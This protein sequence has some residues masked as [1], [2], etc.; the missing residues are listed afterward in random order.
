MFRPARILLE[1]T[2]F[3]CGAEGA[4][5]TFRFKRTA[6]HA[7]NTRMRMLCKSLF[8]LA[9][10]LVALSRGQSIPETTHVSL[11]KV[12]LRHASNHKTNSPGPTYGSRADPR[13]TSVSIELPENASDK[14]WND[15][16]MRRFEQITG[17]HVTILRPGNDTTLVLKDYLNQFRTDSARADVY[18]IDIVW[19]GLLAEYAEDLRPTFGDLRD[20]VPVLAR[21]DIVD[22]KLVALPYFVEVSLLYYR[23]DLLKKYRFTHPPRTWRELE[24]QARTI[25]AGER[26]DANRNFWGY[27]WQGA[28]SE[29]LTC[30][31]LEWQTSEGGGSL[32]AENGTVDFGRAI[33]AASWGRARQWIGS[34]SPPSTIDQLE[35]DSLTIWKDGGA[36]FMRNWPYA[37]QESMQADSK[38]KGRV[39][40]TMLPKGEGQNGR[41]A[42]TLGGFQLMVSKRSRN[43]QSAIELLKFLTS[44]ESQRL[45]ASRG[46]APVTMDLYTDPTVLHAAPLV[47]ILRNILIDGAI[48]RPSAI[49]GSK[50]DALSS[51]FSTSVHDVLS[52]HTSADSAVQKFS[53]DLEILLRP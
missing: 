12:P 44:P 47:G 24:D 27:V 17:I 18:A 34:I 8:C 46:Y 36:A 13:G 15:E 5:K 21:N 32:V 42:D 16:L 52:K 22:G 38:V 2:M 31:G 25:Q 1:S 7:E 29:A 9:M 10:V 37:Y 23:T 35:D 19:S 49:A 48:I 45:N 41:H 43:K 50:Y 11:V 28:A 53:H 39:A 6:E 3:A 33:A 30:N 20:V 51:A 40:V 14:V 4:A 26:K